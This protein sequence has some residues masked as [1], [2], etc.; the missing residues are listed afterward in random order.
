M[1]SKNSPN[2]F[3]EKYSKMQTQ[4]ILFAFGN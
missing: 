3:P 4:K 2:I 1:A